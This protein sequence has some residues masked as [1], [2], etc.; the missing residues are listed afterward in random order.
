MRS[1]QNFSVAYLVLYGLMYILFTAMTFGI[2]FVIRPCIFAVLSA[3]NFITNESLVK[4]HQYYR[5]NLTHFALL[6]K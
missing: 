3:F 2:S 5:R 6:K 4:I 1:A